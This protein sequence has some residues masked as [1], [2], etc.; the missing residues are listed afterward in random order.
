MKSGH[1]FLTFFEFLLNLWL[2]LAESG[3]FANFY[4]ILPQSYHLNLSHI[5]LMFMVGWLESVRT[6]R[7]Y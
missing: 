3:I 1:G 7:V 6:H 2:N 4:S 5:S